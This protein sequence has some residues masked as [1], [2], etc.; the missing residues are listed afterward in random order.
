MKCDTLIAEDTLYGSSS[1]SF[2]HLL[3]VDLGIPNIEEI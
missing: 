2:I 1:S 3:K